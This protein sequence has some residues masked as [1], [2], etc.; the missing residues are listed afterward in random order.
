MASVERLSSWHPAFMPN[1][2]IELNARD[3]EYIPAPDTFRSPVA[4]PN[5]QILADIPS[6]S[7][8]QTLDSIENVSISSNIAHSAT[9]T[10]MAADSDTRLD[11]HN[12]QNPP[13]DSPAKPGGVKMN[14]HLTL[15]SLDNSGNPF[16][17]QYPSR[18]LAYGS[19]HMSTASFT[20][21]VACDIDWGEDSIDP[22][23]DFQRTETSPMA[24]SDHTNHSPQIPPSQQPENVI[25][26]NNSFLESGRKKSSGSAVRSL[27][28]PIEI[29]ELSCLIARSNGETEGGLGDQDVE[30]IQNKDSSNPELERQLESLPPLGNTKSEKVS[31]IQ[32]QVSALLSDQNPEEFDFFAGIQAG[33]SGDYLPDNAIFRKTTF[34]DINYAGPEFLAR[35]TEDEINSQILLSKAIT[36]DKDSGPNKE[37]SEEDLAAKWQA[38]LLGDELLDNELLP[39]DYVG[40]SIMVDPATFFGSDDEGFLEDDDSISNPIASVQ[41]IS[42]PTTTLVANNEDNEGLG[43]KGNTHALNN[44]SHS[45]Y[46]P[47]NAIPVA[48]QQPSNLYIPAAPLLT[49]L[50]H[51]ISTSHH[52]STSKPV[53]NYQ[54]QE[55]PSQPDLP[56]AQSFASKPKGGYTSPYDLPMDIVTSR[57][58][59]SMQQVAHKS[60]SYSTPNPPSLPR[61]ASMP[62]QRP[63]SRGSPTTSP[64][65]TESFQ[66]PPGLAP[67]KPPTTKPPTPSLKSKESFFEELPVTS[68]PKPTGRY[69]PQTN[70]ASPA[71]QANSTLPHPHPPVTPSSGFNAP[72]NVQGPVSPPKVGPYAP[73]QSQQPI[74]TP[75]YSPTPARTGSSHSPPP[76]GRYTS[77]PPQSSVPALVLPYQPRT[78]SPLAHFERPQDPQSQQSSSPV[79]GNIST[80]QRSGLGF[81]HVSRAPSL[82]VTREV[83]E[84]SVETSNLNMNLEPNTQDG[85]TQHSQP[86]HVS[87]SS[88]Q[89]SQAP[90]TSFN[91]G[92]SSPPKN[93]NYI[94][95]R[96][97]NT[98][99]NHV[100]GP[101]R[102]QT[103]SPP[104]AMVDP[105][106]DMGTSEPYK[107]PLS[108]HGPVA[109]PPNLDSLPSAAP[110]TRPNESSQ[111]FNYIAP[112]D[113]RQS[114][115]LQ[116]WKGGPIFAWG[117]GGT[118]VTSFPKEVPRY[119]LNRTSPMII[120][121]PGEIR[122]RNIKDIYL[123]EEKLANFPGPLKNKSKKK[124]ILAWLSAGIDILG[125]QNEYLQSSRSLA[126][127]DKRMEERVLLWKVLRIMIDNDGLLEGNATIN[128]AVRSILLPGFDGENAG[129]QH[130]SAE[131]PEIFRSASSATLSEPA[132]LATVNQLRTLLLGGEREKAIWEAVDKRLWAHAMLISSTLSSDLYR[133]VAQE[134]VQKEVKS[135]GENTESLATLYEIFAG[136][137]EESV[138]ELVPPSARAG[139]QMIS[140]SA[141]SGPSK[142]SL[143]GLDH[144][145]ETLGLIL[146]NRSPGDNQAINALGKLL[147]GYGR[148]EAAHICFIFARSHSVFGGVDDPLSNFVLVGSDHL[149]QPLE[150][151]REIEPI[152]LS[153]IYEYGLSLS[154]TSNI[155]F[156]AP[157]LV[158]YKLHH[159]TI[160]AE[161]GQ[162]DKALQYCDTILSSIHSQTRRSPYHVPFL[163]AI[164]DL[165][166]RLKQSPKDESISWITKPSIDKVSN[167]VWSQFNKFV[168]GDESE[169][170]AI[171]GSETGSDIRPFA[172]IAG[173]TPEIS[174]SPSSGDLYGSYNGGLN[175][176]ANTLAPATRT[177]TQYSPNIP[178]TLQ[179]Q[180]APHFGPQTYPT[181]QQGPSFEDLSSLTPGYPYNRESRSNDEH[182]TTLAYHPNTVSNAQSSGPPYNLSNP[183]TSSFKQSDVYD[184][185]QGSDRAYSPG[186]SAHEITHNSDNKSYPPATSS[187]YKQ[188]NPGYEPSSTTLDPPSSYYGPPSGIYG[189]PSNNYEPTSNNHEPPS[190]AYRPHSK[191]HSKPPSNGNY[192]PT[193]D[194]AY[195]PSTNSYKPPPGSGY[196]PPYNSGYEPHSNSG[197][198]PHSNSG[199]EPHSHSGY[200]PPSITGYEPPSITGY[201]PLFNSEYESHS[202]SGYE[203]PSGYAPPSHELEM[204]SDGS[205]SP[206]DA[207]STEKSS[208]D[209][210][211]RVK[212]T[213]EKTKAERDKEADEAFRR[214]AEAD[215]ESKIPWR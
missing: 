99:Q 69:T 204:G 179:D 93:S 15:D 4:S 207:K 143:D 44:I 172:K 101:R 61:S 109:L 169:R 181:V 178:S 150:F 83:D 193:S 16:Q 57:K 89:S 46:L 76:P 85:N 105:Y 87:Q 158:I 205:N 19:G 160:L 194:N 120:C 79:A 53:Q 10:T 198:E 168:V 82:P 84:S 62:T 117:V 189:S 138:D 184:L 54:T 102:S 66:T 50:S 154:S 174:R 5:A 195:E 74:P 127:D 137:F 45:R 145:R 95:R 185:P 47:S 91:R 103:Q 152:L 196:E 209:N 203:P 136:N 8:S 118:I 161:I 165:T 1:S 41:Q 42:P 32:T 63:F 156:S 164:E 146:S 215:G 123:L 148:V 182:V 173:G 68:K 125:Q 17:G 159:A 128:R 20:R 40:N 90:Q 140:T 98:T 27:K 100:L 86:R 134:F 58:R 56:K 175:I 153:E 180:S 12:P 104:K 11:L 29:D 22:E 7:P 208:I 59:G 211:R 212:T 200:E 187:T 49:D 97:G 202:N 162:R 2:I 183:A 92:R 35:G 65:T 52:P 155:G 130:T 51:Q 176:N 192:E 13:E 115:P 124:E 142:N 96:P 206:V 197:Y 131:L 163:S 55:K 106:L 14:G 94:P 213:D 48:V 110:I 129:S 122:V 23:S 60:N 3:K 75:R 64:P 191:P 6:S 119:G 126:H 113:G 34:P 144:W 43:L 149:Q 114:D 167:S 170:T 9:G 107:R 188:T 186:Q 24:S 81:D 67:Q 151:D 132:N 133:R 108:V 18:G 166:K 28:D 141:A 31:S 201:E 38:V 135:I 171:P 21:S 36:G 121:S 111:A 39:D 214:V 190:N 139:F 116:R 77:A 147:S 70:S 80:L 199:Y 177:S 71:L 37:P 78:S 25:Q 72:P 33:D 30:A 26:G 157:H 210:N 73:I 88:Q 112:T